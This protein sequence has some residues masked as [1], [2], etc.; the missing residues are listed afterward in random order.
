MPIQNSDSIGRLIAREMRAPNK[1]TC[2][3]CHGWV[4]G[5]SGIRESAKDCTKC[6]GRGWV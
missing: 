6:K 5:E 3:R 4:M 2:P 1:K